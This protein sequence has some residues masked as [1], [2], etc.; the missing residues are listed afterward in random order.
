MLLIFLWR[1]IRLASPS[2]IAKMYSKSWLRV[3]NF[4][5]TQNRNFR[6]NQECGKTKSGTF[7]AEFI[8]IY[9]HTISDY[10]PKR[11]WIIRVEKRGISRSQLQ[12][13]R[14]DK[15]G[16]TALSNYTRHTSAL[17]I[18]FEFF[19]YDPAAIA[20]QAEMLKVEFFSRSACDR[21]PAWLYSQVPNWEMQANKRVWFICF[22]KIQTSIGDRVDL[23]SREVYITRLAK[24]SSKS[25][26]NGE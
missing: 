20:A 16:Q 5:K 24:S 15:G 14:L 23:A 2:Q 25:L 9:T 8:Y 17:I 10:K 3:L 13:I 19:F 22:E 12:E 18:Y 7:Q 6:I 11:A 4:S 21:R 1:L 26:C